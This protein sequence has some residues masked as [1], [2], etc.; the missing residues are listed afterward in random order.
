[1]LCRSDDVLNGAKLFEGVQQVVM[2]MMFR[3]QITHI[4]HVMGENITLTFRD[5]LIQIQTPLMYWTTCL[6][7]HTHK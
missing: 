5:A 6:H 1:M 2:V 3:G 7:K 4:D